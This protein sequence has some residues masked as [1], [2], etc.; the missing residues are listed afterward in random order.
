MFTVPYAVTMQIT[1]QPWPI[2]RM[3]VPNGIW[4][5]EQSRKKQNVIESEKEGNRGRERERE[6]EMSATKDQLSFNGSTLQWPVPCHVLCPI[7]ID[8]IIIYTYIHRHTY[9]YTLMCNGHVSHLC[10][11][12]TCIYRCGEN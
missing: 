5:G 1:V 7:N 2:R 6:V 11:C 4:L 8:D 12:D 9:A 3:F 10:A